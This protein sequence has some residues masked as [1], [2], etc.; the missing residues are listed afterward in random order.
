MSV[1]WKIGTEQFFDF[2]WTSACFSST[3]ACVVICILYGYG[4]LFV[5][6]GFFVQTFDFSRPFV[7]TAMLVSVEFSP[8]A[9]PLKQTSASCQNV[10]V[11]MLSSRPNST[12]CSVLSG[13]HRA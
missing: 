13:H 7:L 4:K 6:K 8:S 1:F 12:R 11:V 10:Q 2:R 3:I 9:N 5:N